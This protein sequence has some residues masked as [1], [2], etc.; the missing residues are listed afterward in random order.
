MSSL[1]PFLPCTWGMEDPKGPEDCN[2]LASLQ[3]Y[4]R[5]TEKPVP[6]HLC[7]DMP[8][9]HV[10]PLLPCHA[11]LDTVSCS[12]ACL[13]PEFHL[14]IETQASYFLKLP[15]VLEDGIRVG[16]QI[17]IASERNW[18]LSPLVYPHWWVRLKSEERSHLSSTKVYLWQSFLYKYCTMSSS[19][20]G[21][22]CLN[23][24]IYVA[25]NFQATNLWL[26]KPVF[27]TWKLK[28]IVYVL[29]LM[30]LLLQ[31]ALK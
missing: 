14:G 10:H 18:C 21:F 3:H 7:L 23:D 8:T 25:L 12:K 28:L 26:P 5:N 9:N 6:C 22:G 24:N 27:E 31:E 11:M 15:H 4:L 16:L 2:S 1:S 19:G 20:S 29:V 30:W 13:C 17:R